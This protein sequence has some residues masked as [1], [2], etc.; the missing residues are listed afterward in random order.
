M[1]PRRPASRP[2]EKGLISRTLCQ[3]RPPPGPLKRLRRGR[4][5]DA[6]TPRRLMKTPPNTGPCG[7]EQSVTRLSQWAWVAVVASVPSGRGSV[8]LCFRLSERRVEIPNR[9]GVATVFA[10]RCVVDGQ[11]DAVVGDAAGGVAVG[12]RLLKHASVHETLHRECA[13]RARLCGSDDGNRV[14]D[15]RAQPEGRRANGRDRP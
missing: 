2:P 13:T 14:R 7:A 4:W 3:R 1:P 5:C 8:R 11:L 15:K 12:Y 10:T 6:K 9:N